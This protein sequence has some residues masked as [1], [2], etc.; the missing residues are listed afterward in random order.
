MENF[1]Q[2]EPGEPTASD[3]NDGALESGRPRKKRR[4]YYPGIL[5]YLDISGGA[6]NTIHHLENG[7]P[8][9]VSIHFPL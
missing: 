5:P 4:T 6:G 8:T 7:Q 2:G 9:A 3:I 1:T